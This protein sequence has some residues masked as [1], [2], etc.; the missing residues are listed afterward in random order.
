MGYQNQISS[1]ILIGKITHVDA[2]KPPQKDGV[3][4]S[5]QGINHAPSKSIE[6]WT[7]AC[8]QLAEREEL[9]ES[10]SENMPSSARVF[11]LQH[12]GRPATAIAPSDISEYKDTKF[13]NSLGK[14]NIYIA[15]ENPPTELITR[16]KDNLTT[17]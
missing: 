3:Q 16:K 14:R 2:G 7:N 10:P 4:E 17:I 5:T 11:A 12:E 15:K 8:A 1:L 13:R 9:L 6:S